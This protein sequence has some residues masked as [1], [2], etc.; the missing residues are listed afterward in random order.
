MRFLHLL[1]AVV[2][3]LVTACTTTTAYRQKNGSLTVTQRGW[4]AM[5][6]SYWI[7]G[8]P[9]GRLTTAETLS[10]FRK[11]FAGKPLPAI[12][13]KC[14]GYV[15]TTETNRIEIR[16]VEKTGGNLSQAW[17]NGRH[18]LIDEGAPKPFYHWLIP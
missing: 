18:K 2:P 6:G 9:A 14:S 11:D 16:L 3:L 7:T 15:D 13:V 10:V 4:G 5:H 1:F 8:A 12:P 17:A